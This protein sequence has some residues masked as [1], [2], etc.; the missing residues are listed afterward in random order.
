MS[1]KISRTLKIIEQANILL[2]TDWSQEDKELV[3]RI[4]GNL[5]SY[6]SLIP[7]SLKDDITSVLIMANKIKREY[8]ELLIKFK[9]VD[10]QNE[11]TIVNI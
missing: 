1:I 10:E 11:D 7:N 9:I 8:D 5:K 2:E 4:V 3:Q 6:K